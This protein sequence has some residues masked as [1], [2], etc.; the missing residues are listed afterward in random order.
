[1]CELLVAHQS[2]SWSD[3]KFYDVD[4]NSIF[5]H[6]EKVSKSA[7]DLLKLTHFEFLFSKR[8]DLHKSWHMIDFILNLALS[9]LLLCVWNITM[10][11]VDSG[12]FYTNKFL[13]AILRILIYSQWM[14]VAFVA[15]ARC[16]GIVCKWW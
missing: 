11:Y 10:F 1:M 4:F 14:S 9:D 6:E 16:F 2:H 12:I 13:L 3:R 7:N 15:L 5:C 8:F